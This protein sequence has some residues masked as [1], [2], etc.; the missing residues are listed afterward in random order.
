MSTHLERFEL[1]E[2]PC[3]NQVGYIGMFLN[4]KELTLMVLSGITI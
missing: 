4:F 1:P 2:H 3:E